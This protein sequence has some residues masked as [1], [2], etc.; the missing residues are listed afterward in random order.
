MTVMNNENQV[1][2]SAVWF[3]MMQRGDTITIADPIRF[4]KE[5]NL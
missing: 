1:R 4:I 2:L 5:C 3:L